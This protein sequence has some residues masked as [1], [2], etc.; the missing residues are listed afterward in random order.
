MMQRRNREE[1]MDRPELHEPLL[2]GD[3][4]NLEALN[5]F[6][7]GRSVVRKH[8]TTLLD[9][10]PP[11]KAVRI[12][13]IGSG[14]GDLC[15]EAVRL[16]REQGVPVTL[17]SLDTH[18]QIQAHARSRLAGRFPEIRFILSDARCIALRDNCFDLA[19][20]TLALHHFSEDGAVQVLSE[21]RRVSRCLAVVSDL[22]RSR[23]AYAA[24]WL[25]TRATPNPMT[26]Y[27]GPVS[28]ERAFTPGELSAL[29][30]QAGWSGV[31]V[32]PEPWFRMSAVYR[33]EPA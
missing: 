5:R 3:L 19:L 7:G 28:V 29:A 14:A 31:R 6:F 26:R 10:T 18:P 30:Q 32:R 9:E 1:Q 16:C 20:C 23:A 25:A 17:L 12:L 11:G 24:V 15:R 21:M 33:K 27:D 2:A 4:H 8:V 13:D 22:A